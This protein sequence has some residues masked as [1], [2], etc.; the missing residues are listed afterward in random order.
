MPVTH[1]KERQ[2]VKCQLYTIS[3][4]CLCLG[5]HG[6]AAVEC[7]DNAFSLTC[8]TIGKAGAG[9]VC[10]ARPGSL[11]LADMAANCTMRS[12]LGCAVCQLSSEVH[13]C[14]SNDSC[15]T[16]NLLVQNG[17]GMRTAYLR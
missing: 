12:H 3:K 15:G 5:R 2:R 6:A 17:H 7:H 14:A 4:G 1:N 9:H 13:T 8:P 10:A 11:E 16:Q